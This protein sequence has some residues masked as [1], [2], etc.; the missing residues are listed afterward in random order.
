MTVAVPDAVEVVVLQNFPPAIVIRPLTKQK[1]LRGLIVPMGTRA[2]GRIERLMA[3]GRQRHVPFRKV[4]VVLR[5]TVDW[6]SRRLALNCLAWRVRIDIH[7]IMRIDEI[8]G[9]EPWLG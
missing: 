9:H 6:V 5:R 4:N 3:R 1:V 2:A 8:Y 7:H